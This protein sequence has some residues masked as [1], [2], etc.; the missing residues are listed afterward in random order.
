MKELIIIGAGA[1][2]RTVLETVQLLGNY[3]IKGFCA[4]DVAIGE[5]IFGNYQ[6][7][8][9]ALLENSVADENIFFLS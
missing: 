9:N 8:D 2:A 4:D 5:S 7:I 1:H 3:S 6:M